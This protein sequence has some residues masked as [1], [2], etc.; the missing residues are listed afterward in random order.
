MTGFA[1]CVSPCIACGQ[2]FGFNPHLV[3]SVV[4]EGDRKPICR[5]CVERANPLRVAKG[6]PPIVP[7]EGAYEPIAAEEL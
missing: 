4:L 3:P 5:T 1:V 7:V 6:L 2:P